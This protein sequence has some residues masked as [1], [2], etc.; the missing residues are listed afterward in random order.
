[1]ETPCLNLKLGTQGGTLANGTYFAV[2]AY[3][4]KGQRVT[5]YFSQSNNQFIFTV[6]DLEGSLDLEVSADNENFDEFELVIVQNI[7]QGTVS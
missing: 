5:D 1:M 2:I 6:N 7:N 3:L 4:I